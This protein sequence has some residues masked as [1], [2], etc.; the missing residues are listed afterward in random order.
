MSVA[1]VFGVRS[2][3]CRCRAV[4]VGSS[5]PQLTD[6]ARP[7]PLDAAPTCVTSRREQRR[8]DRVAGE[9]IDRA[10][11][12]REIADARPIDPRA[13]GAEGRYPLIVASPL[14]AGSAPMP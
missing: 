2:R 8:C 10:A 14:D 3:R 7:M 9:T 12:E 5:T 1:R 6:A 13:G 4:P 11:V